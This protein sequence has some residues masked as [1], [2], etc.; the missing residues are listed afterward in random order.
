M[1]QNIL[2]GK[3]LILASAS[4]RRR[5]LLAG[6]GVDFTVDTLNS[7]EEV[8]PENLPHP[9]WPEANLTDSTAFWKLTRF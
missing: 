2:K 6:L 8:A 5:E 4:P 9:P 3:K 7:F 1:L